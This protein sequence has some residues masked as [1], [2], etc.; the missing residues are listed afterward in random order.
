[1]SSD[2]QNIANT[3]I[4]TTHETQDRLRILS[5]SLGQ[6]NYGIEITDAKEVIK[7]PQITN[8]PNTPQFVI[9]VM[10]IW[11]KIVSLVDIRYFFDLQQ[12]PP[13]RNTKVI[14]TD[15]IGTPVGILI[16]KVNVVLEVQQ[17]QVQPPLAT[18]K[19]QVAEYTKGEIQLEDDILVLLDLERILNCDEIH[20]W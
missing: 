16:D 18:I 3:G 2:S 12:Q 8:V 5:F 4:I 9:G 15:V 13:S 14:I 7:L 19:G 6:E 17:E 10:N 20:N 11:G 1:M